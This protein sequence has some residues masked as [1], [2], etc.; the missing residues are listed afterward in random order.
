M[1]SL[2]DEYTQVQHTNLLSLNGA[3]LDSEDSVST[4]NT[5]P[6]KVNVKD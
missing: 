5:F 2:F 4:A 1:I 3:P 6:T